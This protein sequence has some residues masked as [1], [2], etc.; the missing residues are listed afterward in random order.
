MASSAAEASVSAMKPTNRPLL[1]F[2][3]FTAL[4][5]L[6]IRGVLLWVVIPI[7]L[8]WWVVGLPAWHQRGVRL[9]QFIGWLDLNLVAFI[10]RTVLRPLVRHP[11]V[12]VPVADIKNVRHF[13]RLSDPA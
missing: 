9:R 2:P 12:W 5:L 13:V 7:G 6:L 11:L 8:I 1:R 10:Q 4:A 3:L